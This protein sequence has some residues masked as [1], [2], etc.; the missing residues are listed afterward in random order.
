MRDDARIVT[1]AAVVV[2]VAQSESGRYG[3]ENQ[4]KDSLAQHDLGHVS[5]GLDVVHG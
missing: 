4:K 1:A 5:K 2:D 3:P